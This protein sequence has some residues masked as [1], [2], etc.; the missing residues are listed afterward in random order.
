MAMNKMLDLASEPK[1]GMA[2]KEKRARKKKI[3]ITKK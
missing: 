3:C 2:R 1:V